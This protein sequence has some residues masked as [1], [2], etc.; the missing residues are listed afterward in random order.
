M[1]NVYFFHCYSFLYLKICGPSGPKYLKGGS[2]PTLPYLYLL[3]I[4][5][6]EPQWLETKPH[7]WDKHVPKLCCKSMAPSHKTIRNASQ[8]KTNYC[9]TCRTTQII[10]LFFWKMVTNSSNRCPQ[11]FCKFKNDFC[12]F[13]FSIFKCK[14]ATCLQLMRLRF[15][16]SS[17][18]N[19]A[20]KWHETVPTTPA[21]LLWMD[22]G[23]TNILLWLLSVV[24]NFAKLPYF[25]LDQCKILSP[26]S[27]VSPEKYHSCVFFFFSITC[28][29][30]LITIVNH[31]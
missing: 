28:K 22:Q 29:T 9:Q 18:G 4:N 20:T 19:T 26:G 14:A 15:V 27:T 5:M 2:N 24:K 13:F 25:L 17:Y 11:S 21:V 7:M 6:V 10:G 16:F 1:H 12:D 23:S 3:E 30:L 8:T 31:G